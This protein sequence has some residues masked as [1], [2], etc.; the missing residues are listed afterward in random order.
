MIP[1]NIDDVLGGTDPLLVD[2]VLIDKD[3]LTI[4]PKERFTDEQYV[5]IAG[6]VL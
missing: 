5:S 2:V 4:R 6:A 1:I 3:E